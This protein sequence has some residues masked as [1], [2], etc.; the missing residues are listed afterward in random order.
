MGRTRT[1][2]G[3][4]ET[5][6]KLTLLEGVA[7]GTPMSLDERAGTGGMEWLGPVDT[8]CSIRAA[9][10]LIGAF[11]RGELG[12]GGLEYLPR[13]AA[14]RAVASGNK[15]APTVTFVLAAIFALRAILGIAAGA[16]LLGVGIETILSAS[17]AAAAYQ[18]RR[19]RAST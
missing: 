2:G 1:F 9:G 15:H 19:Q 3:M 18:L 16:G 13:L 6:G 11:G 12:C 17:T 10:N 4:S 14:L 8:L 7:A 5:G